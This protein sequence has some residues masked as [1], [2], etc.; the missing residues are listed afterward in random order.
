V[1]NLRKLRPS[2]VRAA[3]R[4][5]WFEYRVPH[6]QLHDASGLIDLGTRYG[7]WIVPGESI[8]SS[9]VCYSVG[10]GA[11]ISFDLEL[12]RRFQ[13]KVRAIDPVAEYVQLAR[14]Q[15]TGEPLFSAYQAAI[16]DHDGPLRMQVTHDTRSHSVSSA[17]LYDSE[18][19]V[20]LPGRTLMSLMREFGDDHIDLLKLDIEGSEYDILPT[21]DLPRMG[22]KVFAAQLHHTRPV[23]DARRLIAGLKADGYLPVACRGTVKLTFVR[24]SGESRGAGY[25]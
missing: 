4:R 8:R 10:S 23:R 1:S 18:D 22:V 9:W 21:L 20:E 7:G 5:R 14:E 15:A 25:C 24:T 16:A 2:K 17:N 12:I 3:L 13:V 19:Y 6:V 11:D